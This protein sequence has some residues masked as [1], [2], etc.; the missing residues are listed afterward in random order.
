MDSEKPSTVYTVQPPQNADIWVVCGDCRRVTRHRALVAVEAF[1]EV[2]GEGMMWWTD[3]LIIQC[4]GCNHLSFCRQSRSTEDTIETEG[5]EEQVITTEVYPAVV[6]GLKKLEDDWRLPHGVRRIYDET[7]QAVS[8]NQPILAGIG[9]RAIVEAVC[10]EENAAGRN[11]QNRI[12][13][14]QTKSLITPAGAQVLH[15]L[16]FMGNAAAHEVKAHTAQELRLALE[17]VEHLL[18]GVYIVPQRAEA[19]KK[20]STVT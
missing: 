15:N 20:P 12:D 16:R 11:L 18:A 7:Y 4:Q 8:N 9:I 13:D 5:G 2:R 19:L 1:D 6:E 3:H 10:N 14:L 17:V